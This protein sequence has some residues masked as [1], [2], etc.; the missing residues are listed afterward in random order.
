MQ[1]LELL[2]ELLM[3]NLEFWGGEI[4]YLTPPRIGISYRKLR[5]FLWSSD[6]I[7]SIYTNPSIHTPPPPHPQSL[8]PLMKDFDN[9]KT[10]IYTGR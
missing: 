5:N 3:D 8:E 7:T 6:L 9:V 1:R 10:F 2:M 4:S